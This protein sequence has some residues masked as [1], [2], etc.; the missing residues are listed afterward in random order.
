MLI[1][2]LQA[3]GWRLPYALASNLMHR[4]L[5]RNGCILAQKD[6]I[7][8]VST[9]LI[10]SFRPILLLRWSGPVIRLDEPSAWA[11]WI[12]ALTHAKPIAIN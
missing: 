5:S 4:F 7:W 12:L 1:G 2:A 10:L 3:S 6:D 9:I 8:L 11:V